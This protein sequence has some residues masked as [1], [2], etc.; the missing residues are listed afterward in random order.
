MNHIISLGNHLL[1]SGYWLNLTDEAESYINTNLHN[2]PSEYSDQHMIHVMA[3]HCTGLVDWL[4]V[5]TFLD[6]A[7]QDDTCSIGTYISVLG[8]DEQLIYFY[9]KVSPE[10]YIP[11]FSE[12]EEGNVIFDVEEV[13]DAQSVI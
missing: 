2:F 5:I 4:Q 3:N 9:K 12:D 8:E 10:W 11:L 13:Q 1:Q 7:V 6:L